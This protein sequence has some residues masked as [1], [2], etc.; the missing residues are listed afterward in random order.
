MGPV[1][2]KPLVH[3]V[4]VVNRGC[5]VM[6]WAGIVGTALLELFLVPEVVQLSALIYANFLQQN[7]VPRFKTT[8]AFV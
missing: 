1:Q 7:V 3:T 5:G 2:V 4:S 6:C 8:A